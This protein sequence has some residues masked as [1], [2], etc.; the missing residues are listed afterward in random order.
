MKKVIVAALLLGLLASAFVFAACGG[1]KVPAGAIASVGDATVT[2]QQF[3]EIWAQA[4]AQYASSAG[5][6]P[7]PKEGTVQYNQYKASIV[8]YLVQNELVKQQAAKMN[9]AVTD[10]EYND[11]LAQGIKSLGGQ[12]QF[13][14]WLKKRGMTMAQLKTQLMAQ[15]LQTKVQAKVGANAK[16]TEA[17][18][19]AYYDDPNNKAQFVVADQVTA[20]HVLV[21]T[22][23]KALE[24]QK[25]LT[26][27]PSD[28][29]W[30]KVAAKYSIDP[31]SKN[32]SGDLGTFGK[33]RMV[34][35]VDKVVFSIKPGTIS[36]PVKSQYGWHVLEVTKKTP[37]ST[38]TFAESK[39]VIEQYLKSQL[40]A[41]AWT[42][43]LADAE[44]KVGIVYATGFDPKTLTASPSPSPSAT[45]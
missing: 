30:K 42:T 1:N 23:A 28:A 7:F 36:A 13:D 21:N 6:P 26:A 20:R 17:Q 34:A 15:M 2:Q 44:K 33:G 12:K 31:G 10:K 5:A 40:Q 25:L 32:K 16:V 35:P 29:N 45:K 14:A 8:K 11:Y 39:A 27:D 18:I 19:K 43:W 24:V 4:K 9:I 38:K 22:K 41:T 3:D 37:G